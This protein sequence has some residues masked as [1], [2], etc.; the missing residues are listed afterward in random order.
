MIAA[1]ENAFKFPEITPD[2]FIA[3]LRSKW[4]PSYEISKCGNQGNILR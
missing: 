3:H 4:S 2:F 1:L